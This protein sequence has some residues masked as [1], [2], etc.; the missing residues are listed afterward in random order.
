M[1]MLWIMVLT[2]SIII[3]SG[4]TMN[5]FA[6]DDS[7]EIIDSDLISDTNISFLPRDTNNTINSTH[8][9]EDSFAN[10][11]NQTRSLSLAYQDEISKWQ[12]G[13]FTNETM[14]GITDVYLEEFQTILNKIKQLEPSNVSYE[15]A[16]GNF[17]KSIE[18]EISSHQY[19][20]EYIDSGNKTK[21]DISIQLL[22]DALK[23]EE[24]AFDAFK[25]VKQQYAVFF[26]Q[27]NL[28]NST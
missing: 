27:L 21:D 5:L 16:V 11:V 14:I 10:L 13:L 9:F 28:F 22:T 18:A 26:N 4:I 1:I 7:G 2:F 24:K 8:I 17:S 6:T 15:N 20:A 19:F 3:L 25:N 23:Y 12:S